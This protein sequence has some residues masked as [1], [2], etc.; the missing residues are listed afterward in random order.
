M[1]SD[2]LTITPNA[3]YNFTIGECDPESSRC[4][5]LCTIKLQYDDYRKQWLD[6]KD[7]HI[8]INTLAIDKITGDKDHFAIYQSRQ[9]ESVS[10]LTES[11]KILSSFVQDPQIP[12]DMWKSLQETKPKDVPPTSSWN[13]GISSMLES[14]SGW[15]SKTETQPTPPLYSGLTSSTKI[16]QTSISNVSFNSLQR[17]L[18]ISA[19]AFY[20]YFYTFFRFETDDI[21]LFKRWVQEGTK[22]QMIVGLYGKL[23]LTIRD[24]T[25]GLTLRGWQ[26]YT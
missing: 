17:A 23:V 25:S 6:G 4:R 8:L 16:V 3:V 24:E 10:A 2:P 5:H 19:P 1:S 13:I 26:C 15:M 11:A 18:Y 20:P 22:L 7:I 21:P 14:V 12:L 9:L